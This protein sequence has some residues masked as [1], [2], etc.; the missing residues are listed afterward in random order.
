MTFKDYINKNRDK[1]KK[2]DCGTPPGH[3]HPETCSARI[4]MD[5]LWQEWVD[6]DLNGS[7]FKPMKE[8]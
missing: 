8:I 1:I 2:C 4:S 6:T 5:D 7:V 3:F